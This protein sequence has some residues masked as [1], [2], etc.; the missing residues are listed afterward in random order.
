M[1]EL[2]V[3]MVITLIIMGMLTSLFVSAT[4]VVQ[5]VELKLRLNEQARGILDSF[6]QQITNACADERG[7]I[8]AIK[9]LDFTDGD[10]DPK[11]SKTVADSKRK[12]DML[13]Y[14]YPSRKDV[15]TMYNYPPSGGFPYA[16]GSSWNAVSGGDPADHTVEF[17]MAAFMANVHYPADDG[18]HGVTYNSDFKMTAGLV[19]AEIFARKMA[20]K[21]DVSRIWYCL[22]RAEPANNPSGTNPLMP[23]A[24]PGAD[25]HPHQLEPGYEYGGPYRGQGSGHAGISYQAAGYKHNDEAPYAI[26]NDV[27]VMDMS[28]AVWD[29][30]DR[31]FHRVP[32]LCAVYFAPIPKAILISM[33]VCDINKKGRISY[34]RI[35]RMPAGI[36]DGHFDATLEDTGASVQALAKK[37]LA[38][39]PQEGVNKETQ[40]LLSSGDVSMG[41][42]NYKL[43]NDETVTDFHLLPLPLNRV[44]RLRTNGAAGALDLDPVFVDATIF[45]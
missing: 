32:S 9:A 29:E 12:V 10:T 45:N 37:I 14:V 18:F 4:K 40:Q 44:K 1:I 38:N 2:M 33:T 41:A 28:I 16:L 5:V 21:N 36:G 23:G 39:Y 35:V 20:A 13:N 7:G 34:S 22:R 19:A 8:F 11:V 27:Y 26:F 25:A 24:Y 15:K 43:D 17:V 6:E 31:K 30:T 3:V 42:R